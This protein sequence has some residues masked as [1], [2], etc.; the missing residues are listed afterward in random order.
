MCWYVTQMKVCI[1]LLNDPG[2]QKNICI[3]FLTTL[4]V[5]QQNLINFYAYKIFKY[6]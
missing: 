5:K 6:F 2:N 4:Q 1:Y 3:Q